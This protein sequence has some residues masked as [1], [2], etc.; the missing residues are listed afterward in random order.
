MRDEVNCSLF[1]A[2]KSY[3]FGRLDRCLKVSLL[4][5]HVGEPISLEERSSERIS[6]RNCL[7]GEVRRGPWMG[8]RGGPLAGSS[9]G[10]GGVCTRGEW[11]E[12]LFL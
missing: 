9:H 12:A 7:S 10:R 4:E 2:G 11:G 6:E 8:S 3:V 1:I 5:E